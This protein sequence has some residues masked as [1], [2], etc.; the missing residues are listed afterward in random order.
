LDSV[1]L[2]ERSLP[3]CCLVARSAWG[4][5]HWEYLVHQDY[6]GLKSRPECGVNISACAVEAIVRDYSMDTM[7]ALLK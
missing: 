6:I 3:K 7:A 5:G 2:P 1:V 4:E